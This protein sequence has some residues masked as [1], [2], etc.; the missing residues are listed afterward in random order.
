MPNPHSQTGQD[1]G[2]KNTQ[3]SIKFFLLINV[4]RP[5]TVGMSTVISSKNSILGL[6]EPENADFL[7]IIVE[8]ACGE[9]DIVITIS[10]RC[11]CVRSVCV[12]PDLSGP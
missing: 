4:Q 10:V 3:L 7:H 9:R 12:R 8:S 1:R 5:I 6:V 2:Y 11:S